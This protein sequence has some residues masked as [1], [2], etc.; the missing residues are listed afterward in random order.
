MID[1]SPT[2]ATAAPSAPVADA[3]P[4]GF[5]PL[6]TDGGYMASF[7]LL[8]WHAERRI[9]G[10][11]IRE[12]H[13]N[14]LGIPHGGMMATLADT[15]IGMMMREAG[16]TQPGVTVQ[17]SLDYLSSAREGDWVE[18]HVDIDKMGARLRF[19]G[20][21]VMAGNRCLVKASATFAVL[22]TPKPSA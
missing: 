17:L 16:R 15:A 18:A 12:H 14:N 8:Y 11:R 7:G 2:T 5:V 21:R 9:V 4:A 3:A 1:H 19:G 13:L 6:P 20:C 22:A 10:V